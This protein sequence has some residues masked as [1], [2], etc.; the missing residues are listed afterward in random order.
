MNNKIFVSVIVPV[1]NVEKYLMRCYNSIAAQTYD[2]WEALLIDDGS[3][4]DSG[5]ICDEIALNDDRVKV[6]H[7]ENEGP[8]IARNLGIKNAKGEYLFFLDSDDYL[9]EN[10]I[11]T[12]VHLTDKDYD[13]IMGNFFYKEMHDKFPIS[14]GRFADKEIIDEILLRMIG[15]EAGKND[16]I[17]S[18]A[19]GKLYK[20]SIVESNEVWFPPERECEDCIFN[21]KFLPCCHSAYVIESAIYHY[22]YNEESLTHKYDSAKFEKIMRAYHKIQVLLKESG[23][24]EK[25]KGRLRNN[26]MGQIRTCLKIE[27]YYDRENGR[28]NAIKNVKKIITNENTREIM[29]SMDKNGYNFS[30]K[31]LDYFINKQNAIAVFGLCKAQNVKKRID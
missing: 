16:Q 21:L 14:E 4:D 30:Q 25:A 28:R 11:E 8:G 7:K 6:F 3:T 31:V 29:R 15:S 20:K 19:C 9:T 17:M 23:L 1:Y 22:C 10:A 2:H 12:L 5:R 13:L 26:F 24:L 18:S 27:A